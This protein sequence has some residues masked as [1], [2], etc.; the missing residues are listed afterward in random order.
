MEPRFGSDFSAV[1][2]HTDARSNESARAVNAMAYTVGRDVV[3]RAGQYAP[4]TD[5]GRRL[6]AHELTHVI[7]QKASLV[8]AAAPLSVSDPGDAAE[9]EADTVA[10]AVMNGGAVRPAL[11][12]GAGLFRQ[13]PAPAPGVSPP[14]PPL[15]APCANK[16]W[17]PPGWLTPTPPKYANLDPGLVKKMQDSYRAHITDRF[18]LAE[19]FAGT[20]PACSTYWPQTFWEAVDKI[21]KTNLDLIQQVSARA[22]LYPTLWNNIQIIRWSWSTS[23]LGFKFTGSESTLRDFLQKSPNFCRD[24]AATEWWYHN[25]QD[26]WREVGR[27]NLPGLHVCLGGGFPPDI[28]IDPHQIAEGKEEDGKCN[29]HWGAWVGHARDQ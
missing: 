5:T 21:P 28:H 19:G 23:S 27:V 1:R 16:D 20:D 10:N 4:E 12:E 15:P 25:N 8:P 26:C 3:F 24:N 22:M 2:V 17:P 11:H 13:T 7:Q 9:K 18:A 14:S 29:I 6:L